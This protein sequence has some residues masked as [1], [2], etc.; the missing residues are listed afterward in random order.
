MEWYE[1]LLFVHIAMAAIW[2]G[3]ASMIQFFALRAMKATNPERMVE[4]GEDVGWISQRVLTPA[5]LLAVVSGVLMVIDSDFWG[6]GDDW[7]VLGIILF[8]IT[9]L[10]G[11]GFFGPEA[12]RVGKLVEAEG[13]ASPLVQARL[14]R[15][16]A[17]SRAD[18]MLL[19]LIIFDMA[20][21]PQWGNASLWIAVIVFGAIAAL[22]VRNGLNARLAATP[23]TAAK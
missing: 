9:F 1:F 13:P 15:L 14:T 19:F 18:L 4:F 5:A 20:V 16:L 21:K 12:G 3:G 22:L 2:V 11:A 23:A 6:F 17:L 8:A 7:I 10:A